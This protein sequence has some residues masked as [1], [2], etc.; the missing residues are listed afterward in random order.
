MATVY[1]AQDLKHGRKVAIKVLRPELAAVIGAERFL[2]EIQTIATLQHPHIL[3]LIDSGEANGTAYYVMPFVEGESLRDRLVREKQLPIPEAVRI[4]SEVAAALD[5]AHRHGVIHRDIKPENVMLHD[6]SALVADFGIALAVSSAGGARMTETGMSLGTPHYMSPEQAMGE[7]AITPRSDVYALGAMTYEMLIGDPPFTGSTAQA[8]VAKVMTDKPAS[9]QHQRERV[10]DA[11]EDAVLTALE[12]LPADRFATAAEFAAALQGE[13]TRRTVVRRA[14]APAPRARRWIVP[15]L[16]AVAAV[17]TVA[18]GLMALRLARPH[19]QPV[20]RFTLDIPDLRVNFTGFYGTSLAISRD[21]SRMAFVTRAGTNV[22]RLAVRDRADLEP[23]TLPGTEGGDG[24]FFSPDGQ[25]I[26]YFA[27]AKMY[28]VPVSGGAP[29][30][31]ADRAQLALPSGLWLPDGRIVYTGADYNIS[32]VDQDGGNLTVLLPAPPTG[33]LAYPAALLDNRVLVL[34]RCGN[35]C[36][37]PAIVAID[38]KTQ[39]EDTILAGATHAT[40][41]PDGILIAVRTDGTV[42]G[43][44]FDLRHHRLTRRPASLLSGVQVEIGVIAELA[45]ADDG[46][47]VYLPTNSFAGVSTVV[48]V[49]R[50]GRSRVLDPGWRGVFISADPSPD[51]RSIAVATPEGSGAT[52]WVKQLDAG[53]LTRLT[54][55][56]GAVNY[57]A[58]WLPDG[59]S[60]S[61]S[62]DMEH[63]THLYRLRADGSDKPVR[64]FPNDTAQ[65]DEASW[66]RDGRW[67]GYRTGTVPGIRDVYLRRLQ[68][69]STPIPVA[70]GQADEYMPAMSPDGRWIAYVSIESG[71]EEVYV[72]PVPDPGRARWQ[73]SPAGG[74]NPVWGP[75]GRELFYVARGDTMTVAEVGGTTDFQVTGRQA[76]FGTAPF[77]FTPWHQ[78]FGVRPDGRSFIMLRRTD[79][80]A[81]PESRRLAVVLNWVTEVRARLT[82]AE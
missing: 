6:G 61:Y 9:L 48:D 8:I 13:S 60:L 32:T 28:K 62:S 15:A 34:T 35:T 40:L 4:A 76:L 53:P 79:Q 46:T 17:A 20:A 69:D 41:L 68:G 33:G 75:T 11:V 42:V 55:T 1:L 71:Q 14:A 72:R 31:L 56:T 25:W 37:G 22:T 81:G 30:L 44:P 3:G 70:T 58:A 67:L 36:A 23:R 19:A 7:R 54:F 43:A 47:L 66:S 78:G 24:P 45:L 63:G 39:K 77:L 38:I 50:S 27:G 18:A 10:P 49:D 51:G 74:S 29:V 73:V 57:R 52:L 5:Y 82:G 59:R 2:R 21:G 65:I 64:L 12:K 16:V 26:G 80:S